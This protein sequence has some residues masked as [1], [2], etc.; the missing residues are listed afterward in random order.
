MTGNS[1]DKK[2]ETG[3]TESTEYAIVPASALKL[4]GASKEVRAIIGKN[5]PMTT[6]NVNKLNE[7]RQNYGVSFQE[8][9]GLLEKKCSLQEVDTL[10]KVKNLFANY[11]IDVE[12]LHKLAT[13]FGGIDENVLTSYINQLAG[14]DQKVLTYY[15]KQFKDIE[16]R[17]VGKLKKEDMDEKIKYVLKSKEEKET[18]DTKIEYVLK[19]KEEL[20][21]SDFEHLHD[22]LETG[23]LYGKIFEGAGIEEIGERVN[24]SEGEAEGE[25]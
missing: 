24:K 6:E 25:S 20:K 5:L 19:L 14:L 22:I 3:Y 17:R 13:E 4:G 12:S 23:S 16:E 1:I 11:Q 9:G 2:L 21:V 8:I 15:I 7:I 10:C 18:M